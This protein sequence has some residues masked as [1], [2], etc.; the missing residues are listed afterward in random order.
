MREKPIAITD[1]TIRDAHQSLWATRMKTEDMVPILERMDKVGYHSLEAWGGATFDAP[2]RFLDENPWER[3]RT[4]KKHVRNTPLQMLLRGQNLVGYRHYSD[5]IVRRFVHVAAKNGM[6]IFRNFDALNDTRNHQVACEA[7]KEVGGHV[8]A[9]VC[10]TISPVHTLEHYVETA[11][12]LAEMGADSICIKDM[13][14]LLSPYRTYNLVKRFKAE[15]DIPIQLH[16]HYI[17]GMAPMNYLKAIEAGV[18]GID[19]A[20]APLAF[21]NSQ[22][23]VEMMVAS[24][25]DTAYDSGLDLEKLYEIAEYWEDVREKKG[26]QRGVT[27]LT[28][29]RVFSHQVPGGMISNL[30]SQLAEQKSSDRLPEVLEEIPK[31]R[32]EVGYPPLVTPLSQ[33]V[34]TQAV[35]NVLSGKRWGIIPDEMKAY[36]RGHY[37]KP[38]GPMSP[39][40]EDL[41]LKGEERLIE[42][43]GTLIRETFTQYEKELGDL[44]RSEEDVLM[45]ALFPKIAR[46]YL[47]RHREGVEKTVF[48]TSRQIQAVKGDEAMDIDQIKELIKIFEDSEVG[49]LS[50]EEGDT[51]INLKKK[52]SSGSLT[53]IASPH[54][55][56]ERPTQKTAEQIP[57]RK[58][59]PDG[60]KEIKSPMVGMF[61]LAPSPD[62][63]PF[64]KV[65]DEVSKGQ[66][67]CILEA[68]K[69]MNEITIEEDGIIREILIENAKPVEYGQP[70]FLYELV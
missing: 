17:G 68:M 39:E 44:A 26:F 14:A 31:V 65:G 57:T 51:K 28:H 45:Y 7:I 3:L 54:E 66:T 69:L 43:P 25:K 29:M 13:A 62:A 18:D 19:T 5:D 9:A 53:E 1:T 24:L 61:Y 6:N 55:A 70:I 42:R 32:A 8:Q 48:L 34:G 59:Y 2:L 12:K 4:I 15:L 38:P 27:S 63:D 60:W 41:I 10:Y 21:G 56:Q 33:I 30:V 46:D 50:I 36:V 40:I 52:A 23:A 20:S 16:C 37:G 67:L 11:V 22:P 49:E 58:D 35:I 64:V 47:E